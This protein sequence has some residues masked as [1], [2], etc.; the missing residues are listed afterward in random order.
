V[1]ASFELFYASEL[2]GTW[3]QLPVPL[4]FLVYLALAGRRRAAASGRP[5]AGFVAAYCAL[6][7][8]ETLLD[9]VLGGPVSRWL[10]LAPTAQALV[11]FGFVWLGDL[12]VTGLV[13]RLG[14]A[15]RPWLR[16][17]V[18]AT[19]APAADLALYFGLLRG[20]WPEVPGQVLW[21]VHE[22]AFLALVL[23]MRAL[24]VPRLADREPA[25]HRRFLRR[26]LAYVAVYYA[27]W[28]AADLLILAG[29][30]AGWALR[31][32]PNQLYY[33]FWTPF[34]FFAFFTRPSRS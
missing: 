15:P 1:P 20:L 11:M 32:L 4:L 9:P 12:R 29:V 28:L 16:G 34:V 31:L 22:T 6:F 10:G 25:G 13:F 26:A 24:L 23:W 3:A 18:W 17:A 33:A 30:D 19:L 27:L 2:Q 7:A 8:V 21:V 14:R 5:E